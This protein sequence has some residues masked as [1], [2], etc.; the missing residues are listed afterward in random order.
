MTDQLQHGNQSG[1]ILSAA[2][3]SRSLEGFVLSRLL[4]EIRLELVDA[5]FISTASGR[6][7]AYIFSGED[8]WAKTGA[9]VEVLKT[10]LAA[11]ISVALPAEIA[12]LP[13]AEHVGE[14]E[15]TLVLLKPDNFEYPSIRPGA[16]LDHL[17][18][19]GLVI[20]WMGIHH[21]S[22]A[23]AEEFYGPVL[24]VLKEVFK[25]SHGGAVVNFIEREFGEIL[26][27]SDRAAL[28]SE[29]GPIMGR[30]RWERLIEFMT[31]KRPSEV[32]AA[33]KFQPGTRKCLA[34]IYRGENAVSR[35]RDI[36][37]PTNP[38]KAPA[39]TIRREFG[40]ALMI[41]AAHAS[42]SAENAAR[43]L[44]ILGIKLPKL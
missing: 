28:Q 16:L 15:Q 11:E 17:A 33:D 44:Q 43:E 2:A 13:E 9:L 39:G 35:V 42:D 25:D 7:L 38:E 24:P 34:L 22:V 8:A 20:S 21:M 23:Q 3:L 30:L 10:Q 6:A 37:G 36:L 1:V 29:V 26:P 4:A 19:T 14:G 12:R 18:R 5:F 27:E 40:R 32:A 41:N 31:G